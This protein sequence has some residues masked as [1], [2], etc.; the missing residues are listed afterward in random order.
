LARY[1]RA[2]AGRWPAK[3]ARGSS[4]PRVTFSTRASW[5]DWPPGGAHA[6]VCGIHPRSSAVRVRRPAGKWSQL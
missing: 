1:K 2:P 3:S 5:K 6:A 4:A